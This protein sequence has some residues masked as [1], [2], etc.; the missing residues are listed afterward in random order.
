M[1]RHRLVLVLAAL[2][3]Y[4][5]IENLAVYGLQAW[6]LIGAPLLLGAVWV[7][8]RPSVGLGVIALGALSMNLT[9]AYRNHVTLL[10]W[11]ALTLLLFTDDEQA[12]FAVRW[13]LATMYGF[14]AAAKLWPDWLSGDALEALT[15]IAPLLPGSL[16]TAVV[17]GTVLVE[18]GLAFGI[19][20]R[21]RWW[22]RL[23]VVTHLSFLVFIFT[24][25]WEL[26][27]LAVFGVLSLSLWLYA[28]RTGALPATSDTYRTV[29]SR[30]P[31][32]GSGDAV[33]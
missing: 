3:A 13:L 6:I 23:A 4:K 21:S 17:W 33:A 28:N 1:S 11:A 18:A 22:L 14:A 2:A 26:G 8:V 9:P 15:W 29:L 7:L 10:M 25:P 24:E 5:S 12:K 31:V 16:L 20:S 30:S 32:A 27:R 19:W